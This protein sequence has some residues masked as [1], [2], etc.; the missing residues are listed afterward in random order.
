MYPSK[1]LQ[2]ANLDKPLKKK[3]RIS[4]VFFL[5]ILSNNGSII[6]AELSVLCITFTMVLL[7]LV[8][9]RDFC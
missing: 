6:L 1:H 9:L 2:E 3:I 4:T 8:T 5:S 7:Q